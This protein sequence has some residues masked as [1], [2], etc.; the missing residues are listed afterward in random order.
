MT[1]QAESS[2][3]LWQALIGDGRSLIVMSGIILW[4]SGAFALFLSLTGSF[5]PHDVAYLHMQV[6][7]LCSIGQCRIVHFMFHDRVTFGGVLIACGT[8]YIWL[9]EFPLRDGE[10]WA[11][12]TLFLSGATGF[13]SFLTYLGYGYLDTWHGV[14][15]LGLLPFFVGGL[16]LTRRLLKGDKSITTLTRNLNKLNL[17]TQTGFGTACLV[18]TG[19]GMLAAG[20]VIMTVGMTQVFVPEDL[21]YLQMTRAQV[22]AINNHLVPLIAHDRAGFG[23]GLFSCGVLVLLISLHAKL[24]PH[25]WEAFLIAGL[26]GF[27]FAIFVHFCIGYTIPVHLGPA[28]LGAMIF[29]CGLVCT[30]K[31]AFSPA[32]QVES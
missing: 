12:W 27:F 4:F 3:H 10:S 2:Q 23:G 21:L 9:A 29:V 16:V 8:L 15:T 7:D 13:A 11:W 30:F 19:L 18:F 14:A 6:A 24:R 32:A 25:M 26:T 31:A 20:A 22:G 28:F 5:L 17:R 1:N